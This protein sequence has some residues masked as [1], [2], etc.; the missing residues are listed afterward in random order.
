MSSSPALY[1]AVITLSIYY[2]SAVI[3]AYRSLKDGNDGIRGGT[4]WSG[5]TEV[6]PGSLAAA[7]PEAASDPDAA[8]AGAAAALGAGAAPTSSYFGR[9][10]L[11]S[12]ALLSPPIKY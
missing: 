11:L 2:W 12:L 9:D 4:I 8:T 10:S 1:S 6:A 5:R 7:A 3:H